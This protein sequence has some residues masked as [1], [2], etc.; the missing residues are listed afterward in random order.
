[1]DGSKAS[2]LFRNGSSVVGQALAHVRLLQKRGFELGLGCAAGDALCAADGV[3]R[4]ARERLRA[5]CGDGGHPVDLLQVGANVGESRVSAGHAGDPVFAWLR[6]AAPYW[7]RA[8]LVE[9]IQANF[10]ALVANYRGV[11]ARVSYVHGA[12]VE[13]PGPATFYDLRRCS[14]AENDDDME[15]HDRCLDDYDASSLFASTNRTFV[16]WH[17]GFLRN[18]AAPIV[19]RTVPGFDWATLLTTHGGDAV[20]LLLLDVESMD[21]DLLLRFPF[22]DVRPDVVVFEQNYCASEQREKRAAVDAALVALGYEEAPGFL[23]DARNDACYVR[24]GPLAVARPFATRS[25]AAA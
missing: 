13:T 20:G 21:C 8:V 5:S 23:G 15:R 6:R 10:E 12:V 18:G 22:D 3:A 25:S 16:G 24:T 2:L 4:V 1:M 9:P 11:E 14:E 17:V 7:A 19:R